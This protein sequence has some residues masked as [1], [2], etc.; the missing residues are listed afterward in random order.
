MDKPK[1]TPPIPDSVVKQVKNL[2]L[3]G[4]ELLLVTQPAPW[5]I[6]QNEFRFGVIGFVIAIMWILIF[7]SAS[8]DSNTRGYGTA[9]TIIVLI[10]ELVSLGMMFSPVRAYQSARNYIYAVTNKRAIIIEPGFSKD[11]VKSYGRREITQLRIQPWRE[12]F[13]DLLF[14]LPLGTGFLGIPEV[15]EVRK[16]MLE[17]FEFDE[18]DFWKG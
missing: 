1:N 18:H 16:L 11:T 5:R 17:T 14:G 12:G 15:E 9:S 6:A 4:E 8:T 7:I 10:I 2:L 13:D 3:D